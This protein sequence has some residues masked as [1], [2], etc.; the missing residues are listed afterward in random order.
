MCLSVCVCVSVCVCTCV[1]MFQRASI[2]CH[3]EKGQEN[4]HGR[5]R[6]KHSSSQKDSQA[7]CM[8]RSRRRRG[9]KARARE[10]LIKAKVLQQTILKTTDT[11]WQRCMGFLC[12]V[13]EVCF[14]KLVTDY[15]ALLWE[16]TY[17][18]KVS[19]EFAPLCVE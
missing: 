19:C 5:R 14:P 7:R 11:G 1:C 15:W 4:R 13:L 10:V 17:K 12:L 3:V 18:V 2:I 16:M 8:R 6:S 9:E